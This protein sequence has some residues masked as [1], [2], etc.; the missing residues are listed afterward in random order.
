MSDE[1]ISDEDVQTVMAYHE[2]LL[3]GIVTLFKEL[4][5][6]DRAAGDET[7]VGALGGIGMAFDM[8]GPASTSVL[9]PLMVRRIADTETAS[10]G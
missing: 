1:I 8:L 5:D 9:L 3:D 7:D 6:R 4:R 2:Q 10:V